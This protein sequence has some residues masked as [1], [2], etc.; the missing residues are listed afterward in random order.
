MMII[1][2][3]AVSFERLNC[4]SSKS[5]NFAAVKYDGGNRLEGVKDTIGNN[6]P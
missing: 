3:T 4:S 2:Q 1:G 5:L 6:V